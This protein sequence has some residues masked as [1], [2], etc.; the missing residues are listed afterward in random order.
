MCGSPL[1]HQH[2]TKLCWPTCARFWQSEE[3][4]SQKSGVRS[5]NTKQVSAYSYTRQQ[6]RR[7]APLERLNHWA[8]GN[9]FREL[10]NCGTAELRNCGTA[11]LRNCNIWV[12][13]RR[14]GVWQSCTYVAIR[15]NNCWSQP[16]HDQRA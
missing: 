7:G 15:A 1:A 16:R 14:R 3:V 11:K 10:R 13:T 9:P 4:R 2:K 6:N 5:Q 8:S 12:E